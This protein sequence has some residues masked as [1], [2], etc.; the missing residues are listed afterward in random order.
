MRLID[1]VNQCIVSTQ[2]T[3]NGQYVA[4]SYV[5]GDKE[6]QY[7]LT[8]EAY[9]ALAIGKSLLKLKLS[10]TIL[11]AMLL[12]RQLGLQYLWVDALCM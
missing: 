4:L 3:G 12:V 10:Q 9:S 5:W 7:A 2:G 6:Q 1:T 8:A 11:D